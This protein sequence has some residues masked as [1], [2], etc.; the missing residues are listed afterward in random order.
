MSWD[1]MG[2]GEDKTT[3]SPSAAER[4]RLESHI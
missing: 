1:Q 3:L 4:R 2:W